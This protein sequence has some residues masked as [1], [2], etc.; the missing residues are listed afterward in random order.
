MKDINKYYL[1]LFAPVV[2]QI[3]T[4]IAVVFSFIGLTI[5]CVL[6]MMGGIFWVLIILKHPRV[7]HYEKAYDKWVKNYRYVKGEYK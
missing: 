1:V 6:I 5:G 4:A 2:L 3:V 7:R